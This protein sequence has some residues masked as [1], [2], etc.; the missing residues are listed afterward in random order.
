MDF[1]EIRI[2]DRMVILHFLAQLT[3]TPVI[4]EDRF[5]LFLD[6]KSNNIKIYMM[7]VDKIPVG[8]GTLLLEKK[9]IHNLGMVGHIEDIII[10]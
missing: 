8:M 7:L 1:R 4:N 5:K 2:D 10:R 6:T 9:I 3:T